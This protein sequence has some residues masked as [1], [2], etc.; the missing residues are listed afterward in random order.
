M[1][2]IDFGFLADPLLVPDVWDLAKHVQDAFDELS[3]IAHRGEPHHTVRAKK[4]PAKKTA[5]KKAA[6]KKAPAKKTAAK[7]A[8]AKKAPAKNAAPEKV[9]ATRTPTKRA[10]ARPG[11]TETSASND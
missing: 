6:A 4:A 2:H 8:P 9:V 11:P 3:E 5:A 10:A 7:K 1:G